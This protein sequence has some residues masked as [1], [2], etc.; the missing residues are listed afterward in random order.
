MDKLQHFRELLATCI[1]EIQGSPTDAGLNQLH[2]WAEPLNSA[3]EAA[4]LGGPVIKI[5][6]C[7]QGHGEGASSSVREAMNPHVYNVFETVRYRNNEN[8]KLKM[9]MDHEPASGIVRTLRRW[10]AVI[11]D[12]A[13]APP[14]LPTDNLPPVWSEWMSQKQ[15]AAV[16]GVSRVTA[17]RRAKSEHQ[18]EPNPDGHGWRINL[19]LIANTPKMVERYLSEFPKDSKIQAIR[20]ESERV[21]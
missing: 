1:A 10:A 11:P 8:G 16:Y 18:G 17:Q 15:I 6:A 4:G 2:H 9:T 13:T 19:R 20:R 14:R 3:A 12:D 5:E 7:R 21:G